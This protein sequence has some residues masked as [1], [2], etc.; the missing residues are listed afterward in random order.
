MRQPKKNIWTIT[1]CL[2]LALCTTVVAV[3]WFAGI[4]NLGLINFGSKA[5]TALPQLDMWTY[6]SV[7]DGAQEGEEGWVQQKVEGDTVNNEYLVIPGIEYETETKIETE[8]D[9]NDN[10]ISEEE[11]VLYSYNISSL[12]F[13]KVDN[14][15]TLREDNKVLLRFYF[16]ASMLNNPE[17]VI[18]QVTF[19]LAYKTEGYAY[20][21]GKIFDS[22]HLLKDEGNGKASIRDL[23]VPSNQADI[24]AA[25]SAG[26]TP[27]DP[28]YVLEFREDEPRAMQFLQIRYAVSTDLY[29][30]VGEGFA[31]ANGNALVLDGSAPINCGS[32]GATRADGTP[33]C[34]NCANGTCGK[35]VLDDDRLEKLLAPHYDEGKLS[36]YYIEQEDTWTDAEGK[37]RDAYEG[38]YVYIELAPLLDAF[39]MQENILDYFV[40]A[41]MFF[42]VK[43]DVELG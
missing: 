43:L 15:V 2:A 5:N 37:S 39:G 9:E 42:D 3:A 8:T 14:L 31:D 20:E 34:K 18:H 32:A 22:I 1:V 16:D 30:P 12:Q 23:T 35:A 25:I 27:P 33:I 13:G 10:V 40:P 36:G 26:Q 11:K 41:Y 28:V 6:Y 29:S 4:E 7:N 19:S 21:A 24:D 38:F 17:G